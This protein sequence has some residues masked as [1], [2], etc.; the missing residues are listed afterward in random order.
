ME[1]SRVPGIITGRSNLK[2][3]SVKNGVELNKELCDG[4]PL[5]VAMFLED[6]PII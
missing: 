2:T 1:K 4:L 5:Y 3:Q 6:F